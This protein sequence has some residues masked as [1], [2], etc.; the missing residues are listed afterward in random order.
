L[1]FLAKST[2]KQKFGKVK[3][4]FKSGDSSFVALNCTNKMMKKYRKKRKENSVPEFFTI[5]YV[6][7]VLQKLQQVNFVSLSVARPVFN[8]LYQL[9]VVK[10]V[11][12]CTIKHM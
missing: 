9:A 8:Y 4:K 1:A 11:I 10:L 3:S 5:N 7:A 12:Y 2:Q 6:T